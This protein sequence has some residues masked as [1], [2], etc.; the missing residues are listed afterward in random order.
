[1]AA[2]L[3]TVDAIVLSRLRTS[4]RTHTGTL[5]LLAVLVGAGVFGIERFTVLTRRSD[6]PD[7]PAALG[8]GLGW[9]WLVLAALSF[10]GAATLIVVE[11]PW[12]TGRTAL[13]EHGV[14]LHS[15]KRSITVGWID[16]EELRAV[17]VGGGHLYHLRTSTGPLPRRAGLG[18][19]GGRRQTWIGWHPGRDTP[20]SA[21]ARPHLGIRYRAP[22]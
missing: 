22:R 11:W 21:V 20:V 9:G 12:L 10:V 7:F 19:Q 8:T 13:T 5:A 18:L 15:G 2:T 17:P 14:V 4:H 3:L 1:M 16:I 6:L